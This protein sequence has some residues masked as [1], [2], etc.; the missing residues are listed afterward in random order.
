VLIPHQYRTVAF[1][2]VTVD[3]DDD[4]LRKFFL[5]R[6]VYRRTRFVVARNQD[7]YAVA[8]LTKAGETELFVDV[9]DVRVLAGPDETVFVDRPDIDTAVPSQLLHAARDIAGAPRCVVVRGRYEHVNFILDADPRR[10]HV[11]DVAPPWPAKLY[12]QVQ[13]VADTAEELPATECVP[14]VVDL[15][16][17]AA[18]E[19]A[20]HYLLPCRG[21]GMSVPGAEISYLDE[22]PPQADWVLLGCARSRA[23]HDHFYP[24][25]APS[26]RQ[27]DICPAALATRLPLPPGEARLTKCCLLEESIETRGDTVV[28]PWGA[29]FT[30]VAEGLAA[31]SELA[32]ELR[33]GLKGNGSAT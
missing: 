10:V 29:S 9:S 21:G 24:E 30:L 14:Q 25:K 18:A 8:E 1:T 5:S 3:L 22:V 2:D 12:D 33:S 17:I 26:V 6:Q 13:R 20:E 32:G 19:P 11:L 27:I 15:E 7:R 23:I 16:E 31:A 28:V 4:S